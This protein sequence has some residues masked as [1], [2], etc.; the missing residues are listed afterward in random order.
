MQP[1]E[2][3]PS[4]RSSIILIIW[5]QKEGIRMNRERYIK[6]LSDHWRQRWWTGNIHLLFLT[7]LGNIQPD[8]ET[9]NK[10]SCRFNHIL[11]WVR[12][13]KFTATIMVLNFAERNIFA[14]IWGPLMQTV[15]LMLYKLISNAPL[16]PRFPVVRQNWYPLKVHHNS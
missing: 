10:F 5:F 3:L 2:W 13:G 15:P 6:R 7:T 12:A 9:A 8:E 11:L 14:L 1:K 16:D 4:E